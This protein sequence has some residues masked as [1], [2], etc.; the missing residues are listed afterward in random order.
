M[1]I[2]FVTATRI[3]DAVLST[4]I[5]NWLATQHPHARF[6]IACGRPAAPLFEP[7]P[8]L[9]RLIVMDKRPMSG[10]WFALWTACLSTRWDIA[11]DL[12]GSGTLWFLWAG[13]RFVHRRGRDDRNQHGVV[14]NAALLGLAPPP[15]PRLWTR[16]VDEQRAAALMPPGPPVLGIGPT[17]NWRG[18]EWPAEK[19]VALIERLTGG[20]APLAGARV[21]LF[22]AG[23]ERPAAEPVIAAVPAGRR[24]DLVG[25]A[26]LPTIAACLKRCTL[27]IGNDSGLM[28]MAAAVG[29]P[30]LGLFGPGNETRYGPW[31]PRTAVVRTAATPQ[32]LMGRPGFDHL[33]TGTLMGSLTVD[34]VEAAATALLARVR[35]PA[36]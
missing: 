2:L 24:I 34:A 32:E 19:F 20:R 28:H 21:A 5:L 36:V 27:Y 30:T 17:A 25:T 15:P 3:G 6:T 16:R 1:R 35:E 18:K 12:R 26:D 14:T 10:H 31:G 11:V 13:Q 4:G 7:F 33:T 23:A 8:Q 22:G 29:T 9:E